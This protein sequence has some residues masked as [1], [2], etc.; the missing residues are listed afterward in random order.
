MQ[1]LLEEQQ[2]LLALQETKRQIEK[3]EAQERMDRLIEEQEIKRQS[4]K[5]ET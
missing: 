3:Q 5:Q 4:E 1:A 2:K